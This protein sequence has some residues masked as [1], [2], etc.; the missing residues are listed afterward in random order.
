MLQLAYRTRSTGVSMTE[1][2]FLSII[3]AVLLGKIISSSFQM[4]MS[5]STV[6][7]MAA[8]R[9]L[10]LKK[11]NLLTAVNVWNA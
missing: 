7:K 3:F 5:P 4:K 2:D 8:V 11:F 10:V 9:H 6:F 1:C